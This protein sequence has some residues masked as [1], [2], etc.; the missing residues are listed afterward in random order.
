M[1]VSHG[2][3]L[4]EFTCALVLGLG[5]GTAYVC[6]RAV[7][8]LRGIMDLVF[9]L[10]ALAAC[11]AFFLTVCGGLVRGYHLA[12]IFLGMAGII[13]LAHRI[14]KG[15]RQEFGRQKEKKWTEAKR[16]KKSAERLFF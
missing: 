16:E 10:T 14:G 6:A 13:A 12:G 1:T 3:Q 5:L 11:T 9:V 15:K 4:L 2:A 7:R 8:R